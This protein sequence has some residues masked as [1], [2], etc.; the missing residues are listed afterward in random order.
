M[1]P[2]V[3]AKQLYG[4]L[5]NSLQ[6]IES[7]VESAKKFDVLTTD[8]RF[9]VAM[10]DLGEMALLPNIYKKLQEEAPKVELEVLPLE[11]DKL[12]EWMSTGKV[13]AVICSQPIL[14]DNI[15]RRVILKERYVCVMNKQFAPDC[16]ELTIE[17]FINQKHALVSRS[18]GHGLAEDVMAGMGLQRKTSLVLS[19]FSILPSLLKQTDLMVILPFKIAHA[20]SEMTP[21]KI[22]SLPF[23]VPEV[24]VALFWQKRNVQPPSLVWFREV[25][26]QALEELSED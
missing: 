24:E 7:T 9:T 11:I 12:N 23:N 16:D 4:V 1:E 6:Q 19:H 8:K 14:G 21:L 10:T 17:Q 26:T 22:F 3:Y 20:F 5:S 15:E 13:D 25:I 2:T 18:L